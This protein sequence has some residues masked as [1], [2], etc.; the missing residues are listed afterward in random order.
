MSQRLGDSFPE[1][2][3]RASDSLSVGVKRPPCGDMC[4]DCLS[5]ESP[6]MSRGWRVVIL[7]NISRSILIFL[8]ISRGL[9]LA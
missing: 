8:R 5:P 6:G 7:M 4:H 9:G 2:G 3:D 1:R